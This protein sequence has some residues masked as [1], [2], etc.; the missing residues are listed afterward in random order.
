MVADVFAVMV[1]ASEA[2]RAAS[3]GVL[4][5]FPDRGAHL[6]AARGD[7]F[8]AAGDLFGRGGHREGLG[9]GLFGGGG[10]VRGGAAHL[11]GGAG[12]RRGGP[13]DRGDG[14]PQPGQGGVQGAGHP[15][16]LVA[17]VQ[18]G[19]AGQIAV[20]E[21]VAHVGDL[22]QRLHDLTGD[23][24]ADRQSEDDTGDQRDDRGGPAG[25]IARLRGG[26]V[27]PRVGRFEAVQGGE[28]VEHF[29][30]QR[31]RVGVADVCPL[32]QRVAV[33]GRD[34]LGRRDVG[35]GVPVGLQLVDQRG[36]RGRVAG[37]V[38]GHRGGEALQVAG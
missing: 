7:G 31:H 36:V 8:D 18:A 22:G 6:F 32:D 24:R 2:T 38:G 11:L 15:A 25:L 5:D 9:R 19:V 17:G 14:L 21:P 34:Q 35:V 27:L 13:L 3:G 10:D 1:T 23:D 16:G 37:P 26:R 29:R 28:P 4:G 33:A 30:Q 12:Q 20:G